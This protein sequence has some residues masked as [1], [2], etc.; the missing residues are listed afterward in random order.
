LVILGSG[1]WSLV[2]PIVFGIAVSLGVKEIH[3]REGSRPYRGYPGE[4]SGSS[5]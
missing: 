2:P 1:V 4:A 5:R 3:G